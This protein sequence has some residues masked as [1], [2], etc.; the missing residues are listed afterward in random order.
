MVHLDLLADKL[1][2]LIITVVGFLD[3]PL[4]LN[5][6]PLDPS[7]DSFRKM[8]INAHQNFNVDQLISEECKIRFR[9]H[10]WRCIMG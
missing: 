6:S 3:S 2:A 8:M 7:A 5:L 10:E 9:N 1:K 4:W